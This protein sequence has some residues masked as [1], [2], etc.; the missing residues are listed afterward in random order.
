MGSL[1]WMG[2]GCFHP[3]VLCGHVPVVIMG[4]LKLH[5]MQL[6]LWNECVSPNRAW[7]CGRQ[8]CGGD[9]S[10]PLSSCAA[11]DPPGPSHLPP[12]VHGLL[13]PSSELIASCSAFVKPGAKFL[14][15]LPGGVG[16]AQE[17]ERIDL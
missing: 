10:P 3:P 14:L 8:C 13:T 2:A 6:I 7:L 12:A 9:R 4:F 16:S 17:G 1:G 11:R 15:S 5:S